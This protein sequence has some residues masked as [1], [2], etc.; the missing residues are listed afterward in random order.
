MT[1]N[2][3]FKKGTIIGQLYHRKNRGRVMPVTVDFD[4][5]IGLPRYIPGMGWTVPCDV[6]GLESKKAKL[7]K[8]RFHP[9]LEE[10]RYHDTTIVN[11]AIID[12]LKYLDVLLENSEWS[13]NE[14]VDTCDHRVFHIDRIVH[15]LSVRH[16]VLS[17][18]CRSLDLNWSLFSGLQCKNEELR[19]SFSEARISLRISSISTNIVARVQ[20]MSDCDGQKVDVVFEKLD[21]IKPL[22]RLYLP[23]DSS[24]IQS[25]IL[26]GCWQLTKNENSLRLSLPR[27]KVESERLPF[28]VPNI[29]NIFVL[30]Q[31]KEIP[32]IMENCQ[33]RVA[34]LRR[35]LDESLTAFQRSTSSQNTHSRAL[36]VPG[37]RPRFEHFLSASPLNVIC[38]SGHTE[39]VDGFATSPADSTDSGIVISPQSSPYMSDIQSSPLYEYSE[40][41]RSR[42]RPRSASESVGWDGVV[43]KSILKKPQRTDRICRSISESQ[44]SHMDLT[45]LSLLIEPMA[46]I[47]ESDNHTDCE[48]TVLSQRKKRVSFSEKVQ[49]RRFRSGQCILT[50]AKKNEKKRANK[51]KKEE[52]Q[53]SLSENNEDSPSIKKDLGKYQF[54]E[55][56]S[57]RLRSKREDSGFVDS[58]ENDCGEANEATVTYESSLEEVTGSKGEVLTH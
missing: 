9:S 14:V 49:E 13:R 3:V 18:T 41:S 46:E 37:Q 23:K 17:V 40:Q 5:Q 54:D 44:H 15:F 16:P 30:D 21:V 43:L 47:D 28:M 19:K 26:R 39:S 10:Q 51:K 4:Q 12:A 53:R 6:V 56:D 31:E 11:S 8:V 27:A 1:S 35:R 48:G 38:N 32:L 55:L 7:V 50:A 29:V 34:E 2:D 57:P 45:H 25:G 36:H 33:L 22:L 42:I 20:Q 24:Y 52:R 58:E